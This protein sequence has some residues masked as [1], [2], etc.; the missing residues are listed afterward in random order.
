MS[1][2]EGEERRLGEDMANTK[3]A[4]QVKSQGERSTY[5]RGDHPRPG[6]A[7]GFHCLENV[8]HA[9]RLGALQ[10][11]EQSA[12]QP[13]LLRPVSAEGERIKKK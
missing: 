9:F 11:V 6:L 1:K 8:D 12:E 4:K 7:Q 10:E 3:S 13:C 2:K 5:Q